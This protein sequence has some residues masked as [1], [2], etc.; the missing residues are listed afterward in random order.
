MVTV[1]LEAIGLI[2]ALAPIF[3]QL[4]KHQKIMAGARQER[5]SAVADEFYSDLSYEMSLL[6]ITIGKFVRELSIPEETKMRLT[7]PTQL[8]HLIWRQPSDELRNIFQNRLG[9]CT[10][11]FLYS[12]GIIFKQLEKLVEDSSLPVP[13]KTHQIV[14][15]ADAW[16]AQKSVTDICIPEAF[17]RVLIS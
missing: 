10:D 14:R 13:L 1:V 3:V 6:S 12:M 2:M 15:E 16:S 11:S 9:E 17:R 7:D 4:S 8:D 5:H